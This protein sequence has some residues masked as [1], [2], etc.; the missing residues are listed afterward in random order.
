MEKFNA[1]IEH[2]DAIL[3]FLVIA[4]GIIAKRYTAW[5]ADMKM[6]KDNLDKPAH[7]LASGIK[8]TTD[9]VI[10]MKEKAR[11]AMKK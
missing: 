1:I 5:K 4:S 2:L 10:H 7:E 8:R 3:T 11:D 6:I 9:Q